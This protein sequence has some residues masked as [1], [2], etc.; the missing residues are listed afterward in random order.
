MSSQPLP[1]TVSPALRASGAFTLLAIACLTIMVGCVIVPGLTEIAARLGVGQAAG[2]LVTVP[3]LGVVLLGPLA[4]WCIA[5][6]GNYRA[7]GW[8]LFAY[9]LLGAG[10][11]LLEGAPLIF[12]DRFLLGGATAVVMAAGTGLLSHFYHGPARL[13]MMAR[14]GM[15]IELGG[16]IFLFIGGLLATLGWRWPFA[17]YLVAWL[18]LVMLRLWVP[19]PPEATP[20][21]AGHGGNARLWAV[22]GAALCSMISFFTG[23]ITLPAH[24]HHLG[25]APAQIGS[26]LAFV[27]LVAVG[28]A[29]LMPRTATRLGEHGA[30][31]LA[32]VAY[33]AAHALFALAGTL[34]LFIAGGVLMG[35]GFGLSVPL[36]NHLVVERSPAATRGTQLARLSMAI[37]SGQFLA[38][39]MAFM[40]TQG[41]GAF[42]LAA[43]LALAAATILPG[44]IRG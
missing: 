33:A 6:L 44:R 34:P 16:V 10:G 15:A 4:G 36:A 39:F 40:P 19:R 21:A 35:L 8:G 11:V 20:V 2:W 41:G 5:R 30:L 27:S 37:F 14:Q 7:L 32:F 18:L 3:S 26:F 24:L 17:L 22:H 28:A 38:S 43:L 12:A 13:A 23:V 25:L 42:W 31:A 9:G 29:W 1:H